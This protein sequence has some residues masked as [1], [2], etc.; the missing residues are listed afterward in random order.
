MKQF[1]V[2]DAHCDTASELLDKNECL[3]S[4]TGHLSI[5]KMKGYQS[6]VQF[7]AAWVSKREKNPLL[8]AVEIIDRLKCEL[9]KNKEYME[10][11]RTAEELNSVLSRGKHGAVLAIE[12]ARALCGSLSALR[13]FHRLGVR[14]ITLAW[15]DNNDVTDGAASERGAGLTAFGKDVV[16]EMNRL[17]MMV[18]VSHI[19]PRGFWDVLER[20]N[21]PVLASHSNAAAVCG[22]RRNLNDEQICAL[23]QS[24]G[25]VCVNIYPDFLTDSKT[26]D[27]TDVLRHTDHILSLGGENSLGLGSDF[28][29]VDRLPQGFFGAEDYVKLFNEMSR[30]GYSDALIDKITHKNM[31][32]F[33]ER[34][35]K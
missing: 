2:I 30:C 26:A 20:S 11:I 25:M 15:N 7:Y 33:I 24:G 18:D 9:E 4:N 31:V 12:D 21:A 16:R 34:I 19:T 6:Y 10:E 29:G 22:H 3:F 35:E 17:H 14:A 13:M 28:D 32:N 5:E 27:I 23:V 1:T 8:R